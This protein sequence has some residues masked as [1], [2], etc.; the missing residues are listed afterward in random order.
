MP[1][2]SSSSLLV[3]LYPSAFLFVKCG[4]PRVT[5]DISISRGRNQFG[6]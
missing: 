4:I 1:Q 3:D 2:S 5:A 6:V